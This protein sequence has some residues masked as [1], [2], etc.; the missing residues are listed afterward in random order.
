M[1]RID[2]IYWNDNRK[3]END[4]VVLCDMGKDY[5][6]A[7]MKYKSE[8]A[9]GIFFDFNMGEYYH[10]GSDVERWAHIGKHYDEQF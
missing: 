9:D 4:E 8:G 6:F 7:V 3:P 1:S 5:E 2:W 10:M